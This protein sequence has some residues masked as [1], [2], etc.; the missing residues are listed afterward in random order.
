MSGKGCRPHI[1]VIGCGASGMF[2]AL[3]AA[4]RGARVTVLEKNDKAG[5]KVYITGKGRC[6]LTNACDT[7]ESFDAVV[8]G[9]RFL[10][11]AV[12]GYDAS[13]VQ[14][15]FAERGCPVRTERGN[16]VFPVSDKSS[17]VIKTLVFE[18]RRLGVTVRYDCEVAGLLLSGERSYG[19]HR[20]DAA[21]KDGVAA[22]GQRNEKGVP[23]GCVTGVRLASGE[24]LAAD[25]VIVATGG[26]SY[27]ATGSTGDGYVFA[28]AAGHTVTDVFPSLVPFE[29]KEPW[30]RE[31]QGLTLK[32]VRLYRAGKDMA[33]DGKMP[34]T[35]AEKG[36]RRKKKPLVFDEQG[37]LLFTHFGISGPLVLTASARLGDDLH[38]EAADGHATGKGTGALRL[39]IDLK[40]GLT[41]E[42][43]DRRLIRDF[44][45]NAKKQFSNSLGELFPSSLIPVMVRLAA[46]G[47]PEDPSA[48]DAAKGA[49]DDRDDGERIR[50][51]PETPAGQISR[52]QRRAFGALMKRLPVTV[53]GTRGFSEAVITRGGVVLKEINPS[54]MESKLC[55]GLYFAGEVLDCDALTGGFNLQIAW[56]TGYLAGTSCNGAR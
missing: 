16:R 41:P 6:N 39:A 31:L 10:Y 28:K 1:L 9:S 7:A 3:A 23:A 29:T 45:Q 50:I 8:R 35:A 56:S 42:E 51:L 44:E 12:Y 4:E 43:L 36:S 33:A 30:H 55:R 24:E 37:E 52:A 13:R 49:Q 25:A 40:P 54:T 34:G 11:S 20:D 15:F 19:M 5:K 26:L 53:T 22:A 27:P 46:A 17:D 38:G 32:N 21:T 48:P 18:M 14:R 47:M 2:A